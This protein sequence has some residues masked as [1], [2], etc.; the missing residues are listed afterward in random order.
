MLVVCVEVCDRVCMCEASVEC[1]YC[2][3]RYVTMCVCVRPVLD[4]GERCVEVC[5][6]MWPHVYV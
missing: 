1:W 6:G 5:G 2:V 3:W 4:V